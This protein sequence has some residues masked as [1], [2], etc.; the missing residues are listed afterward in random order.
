MQTTPQTIETA[1]KTN[2]GAFAAAFKKAPASVRYQGRTYAR[3]SATTTRAQAVYLAMAAITQPTSVALM[4]PKKGIDFAAYSL[5]ADRSQLTQAEAELSKAR[6]VEAR[7]QAK[8]TAA[9]KQ[10]ARV[11]ADNKKAGKIG[12]VSIFTGGL[13]NLYNKAKYS[14][15]VGSAKNAVNNVTAELEDARLATQQAQSDVDAAKKAYDEENARIRRQEEEERRAKAAEAQQEA[16]SRAQEAREQWAAQAAA[17]QTYAPEQYASPDPY[18]DPYG[19]MGDYGYTD[20]NYLDADVPRPGDFDYHSS[21]LTRHLNLSRLPDAHAYDGEQDLG[22]ADDGVDEA[23]FDSMLAA[24][25]DADA[26]AELA[27]S[28]WDAI[29]RPYDSPYG[30]GAYYCDACGGKPAEVRQLDA[31]GAD[32]SII[33]IILAAILAIAPIIIQAFSKDGPPPS[34]VDPLAVAQAAAMGGVNGGLSAAQAAMAGATDAPAMEDVQPAKP[35]MMP[36]AL[37]IL[38][39]KLLS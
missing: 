4:A 9:K 2:A 27:A 15:R 25:L 29:V 36:L 6:A 21:G 8:L 30:V 26:D 18:A 16:L 14:T 3:S 10:L 39:F 31:Y 13:S 32:F 35:D 34:E 28:S 11:E 24:Q 12:A 17:A 37:G 1:I 23:A 5:D 19:G 38:A 7:L 22:A 33:G 20:S